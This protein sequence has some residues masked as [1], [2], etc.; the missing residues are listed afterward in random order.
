MSLQ[1]LRGIP[2]PRG[3][4]SAQFELTEAV[5]ARFALG[6]ALMVGGI[7]YLSKGRDEADFGKMVTGGI[8][9]LLSILTCS[10]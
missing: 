6:A 4:T 2:A 3:E 9:S 1:S 10:F 8:L 5:A 7:Y